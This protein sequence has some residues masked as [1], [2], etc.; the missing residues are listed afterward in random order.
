MLAC[1][2]LLLIIG[3]PRR[4]LTN[5]MFQI[6]MVLVLCAITVITLFQ[7]STSRHPEFWNTEPETGRIKMM[8]L[9]ALMLFFAIA[10]AGRWIAYVIMDYAAA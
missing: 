1:S 2:G 5:I 4:E 7:R 8:A 9:G 3:E 10:V 6:K